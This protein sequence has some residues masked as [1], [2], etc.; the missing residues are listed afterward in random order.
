MSNLSLSNQASNPDQSVVAANQAQPSM[1][2]D[3]QRGVLLDGDRAAGGTQ[4]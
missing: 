2:N 3:N 1:S 4:P